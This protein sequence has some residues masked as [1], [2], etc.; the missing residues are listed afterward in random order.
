VIGTISKP[1]LSAAFAHLAIRSIE[2]GN[3][4][5]MP[6]A[7]PCSRAVISSRNLKAFYLSISVDKFDYSD[8][9]LRVKVKIAV[10]SY[11]G[12]DLK[13][14]VPAGVTQTGVTPGDTSSE[15]NLLGMAAGRA[16]E[17]FAQNFQ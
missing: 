13:G 5:A 6:T 11:P 1:R 14:E 9:N 8:G 12:K 10:S 17:L 4:E 16:T 7:T 15:D 3:A 2:T